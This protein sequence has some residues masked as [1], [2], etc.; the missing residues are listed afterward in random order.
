VEGLTYAVACLSVLGSAFII[1]AVYVYDRSPKVF[2]KLVVILSWFTLLV[3]R[4]TR[5]RWRCGILWPFPSLS[6]AGGRVADSLLPP[7]STSACRP[8]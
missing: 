4:G 3:R 2:T 6:L 8:P 1:A 7:P 5:S